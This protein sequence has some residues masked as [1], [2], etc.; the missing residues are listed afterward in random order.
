[1]DSGVKVY[2]RITKPD[3]TKL[4]DSETI[5]KAIKYQMKVKA[6]LFII[7]VIIIIILTVLND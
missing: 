5:A 1:M 4:I 6:Y 2:A 7:Q 3:C